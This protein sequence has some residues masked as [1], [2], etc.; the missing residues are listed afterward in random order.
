M[1]VIPAELEAARRVLR[2]DDDS[3]EQAAD[4]TVYFRGAVRSELADRDYA[5]A[6][7]CIGG[8][9][10]PGPAWMCTTGNS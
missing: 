10:N 9:G 8:A 5:V 4:G 2:I 3:R 6:L 1:T 7:T